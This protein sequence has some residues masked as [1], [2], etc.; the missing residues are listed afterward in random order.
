MLQQESTSMRKL[1]FLWPFGPLELCTHRLNKLLVGVY[2][3]YI[4]C[5]SCRLLW[6]IDYCISE[7]LHISMLVVRVKL[8][9][10][11]IME[12]LCGQIQFFSF[13]NYAGAIGKTWRAYW[14]SSVFVETYFCPLF[15]GPLISDAHAAWPAYWISS[16]ATEW[17]V[18][19]SCISISDF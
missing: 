17:S 11:A 1:Q 19:L 16:S 18:F 15:I 6:K 7:F 10:F 3:L 4:T 2:I 8:S 9:Q 5:I 13:L 14:M 12:A